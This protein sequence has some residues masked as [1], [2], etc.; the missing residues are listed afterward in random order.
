[1]VNNETKWLLRA[2]ICLAKRNLADANATQEV[3]DGCW[4]AGQTWD[5][6]GHTSQHAFMRRA[7]KEAGIPHEEYRQLIEDALTADKAGELDAIWS[8]MDTPNDLAKPPGAALC[9]RSA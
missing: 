7:T 1:M 2:L 5:Q 6:L 8:E 4:P 3:Q 9:D